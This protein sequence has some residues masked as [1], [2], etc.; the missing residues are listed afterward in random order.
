MPLRFIGVVSHD[1]RILM[2]TE[3]GDVYELELFRMRSILIMKGPSPQGGAVMNA[4]QRAALEEVRTALEAIAELDKRDGYTHTGDAYAN[5]LGR[6]NGLARA[7]LPKIDS[8]L[9]VKRG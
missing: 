4:Y 8:I 2:F 5:A 7:V 1:G 6:A 3:Q 9:G